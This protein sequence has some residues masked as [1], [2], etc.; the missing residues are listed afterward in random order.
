MR[1]CSLIVLAAGCSNENALVEQSGSDSWLQAAN[2]KVDILFVVDDSCSMEEEQ[3][4]LAAGFVSFAE[5]LDS[6]GTDFRLGVISTSYDYGDPL[7]GSLIGE[8]A[9][10]TAESEDYVSEFASRAQVGIGGL[11]KE[12]GLEV[13]VKA[14]STVANLELNDGFVRSEARMLFIFVSDEEDCSDGGALT[15]QSADECYFQP[16]L[17]IPVAEHVQRFREL[18]DDLSDVQAAAI[19]GL[20]ADACQNVFPGERYVKVAQLTGGLVGDI[21]QGDW[22]DVLSELGLNASGVLRSFQLSQG[23]VPDTIEVFVDG[24]SIPENN[25]TGWTYDPQTWFLNFGPLATPPR[26]AEI[27]AN[28]T[29]Q[30]GGAPPVGR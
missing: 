16:D 1:L 25:R 24:V 12:K 2:D 17:L 20:D 11:D 13:A 26:G 4:T 27:E 22:S 23:A 7:R 19:V 30:P 3:V 5:Q 6:S 15:G 9:F 29:V 10:L 8:P 28:Y 21:C 14:T 18:K